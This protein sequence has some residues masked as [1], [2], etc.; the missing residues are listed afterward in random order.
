MAS[1]KRIEKSNGKT[2]EV[3]VCGAFSAIS[4]KIA[5]LVEVPQLV[6]IRA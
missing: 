3:A 5:D 2:F 6:A 4:D 1:L